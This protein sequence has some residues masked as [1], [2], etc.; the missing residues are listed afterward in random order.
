MLSL[1]YLFLCSFKPFNVWSTFAYHCIP[2]WASTIA[3]VWAHNCTR[4]L[5][6]IQLNSSGEK[7][8]WNSF[9]GFPCYLPV[10]LPS[11]NPIGCLSG[12]IPLLHASVKTDSKETYV[13]LWWGQTSVVQSK[14]Y[15]CSCGAMLAIYSCSFFLLIEVFNMENQ[16]FLSY[17]ASTSC[18]SSD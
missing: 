6:S 12:I 2:V 4:A 10:A 14:G 17:S 11:S 7:T 16:R 8:C 13:Q 5:L 18:A 9:W 3:A 15:P 1:L